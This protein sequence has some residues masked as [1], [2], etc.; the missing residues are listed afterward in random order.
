MPWRQ[1]NKPGHCGNLQVSG[2]REPSCV[3]TYYIERLQAIVCI[4]IV[5]NYATSIA[6]IYHWL[7]SG[8]CSSHVYKLYMHT[9]THWMPTCMWIP[10]VEL[11]K[12]NHHKRL[13]AAYLSAWA[14]DRISSTSFGAMEMAWSNVSLAPPMSFTLRRIKPKE[15]A[16]I[17]QVCADAVTST[18]LHNM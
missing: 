2:I 15:Q 16:E 5:K 3:H 7:S 9:V 8:A 1:N 18:S 6:A 10:V 17:P 4:V 11:A 12:A 14:A 13:L